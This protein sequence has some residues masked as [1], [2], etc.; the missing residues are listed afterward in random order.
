MKTIKN[1]Y[2]RVCFDKNRYT[3]ET[4]EESKKR[5]EAKR[6]MRGKTLAR[7]KEEKACIKN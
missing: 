5:L 1:Y 6:K 2:A 4:L 7:R 3:G